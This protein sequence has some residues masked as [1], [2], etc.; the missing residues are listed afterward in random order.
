[1]RTTITLDE[2]VEK[3]LDAEVRRQ[4]DTSFKDIVNETLRIGLLT[5]RELKAA[6]PFKVEARP[7]GVMPGINYDNIGDLIEHLEGASHK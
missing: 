1:M 3:K 4:K 7:M 6:K 2:D 5:K